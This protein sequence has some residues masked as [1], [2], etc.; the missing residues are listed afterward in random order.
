MCVRGGRGEGWREDRK[1]NKNGTVLLN[2][3]K[4]QHFFNTIGPI[5]FAWFSACV[6]RFSS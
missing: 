1:Q 3:E 2:I 4:K 5:L 6:L